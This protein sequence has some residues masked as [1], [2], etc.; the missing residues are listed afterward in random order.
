M[1]KWFYTAWRSKEPRKFRKL[2]YFADKEGKTRVIA[3]LDYWS[4]TA[5]KSLHENLNDLLKRIECDCTF[6]Q[7]HFHNCLRS[8]PYHSLDLHAA[9]DRMPIALQKRV[10][11]LL[12]GEDRADAWE[13][14]LVGSGFHLERNRST[15]TILYEVGQPMGAYSS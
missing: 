7:N 3:I 12:I 5:L 10:L 1:I 15:E 9:T 11:R 8:G 14:I 2:S 6:N 13:S 4:Q